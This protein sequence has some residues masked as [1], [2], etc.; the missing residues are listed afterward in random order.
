MS[1]RF[2][3]L[4]TGLIVFTSSIHAQIKPDGLNWL[5][6]LSFGSVENTLSGN[7]M[8]ILGYT[9]LFETYYGDTGFSLGLSAGFASM[10]DQY[11]YDSID[12]YDNYN[13]TSFYFSAKYSLNR[14]GRFVPYASVALGIQFAKKET[15]VQNVPGQIPT[16]IFVGR[17]SKTAFN[18]AA[19]LGLNYWTSKSVYIGINITPVWT[20]KSFFDSQFGWAA[21]IA[22]GFQ[23]S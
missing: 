22:L 21:S 16:D 19:P 2:T 1:K 5:N 3:I 6:Y 9:A 4:I 17:Q 13:S 7:T 20:S 14:K 18:I 23:F 12:V 10:E 11:V 15:A 8:D